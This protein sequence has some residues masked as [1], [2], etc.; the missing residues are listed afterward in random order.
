MTKNNA[1][2]WFNY[3]CLMRMHS[4]N[5]NL[6]LC[7]IIPSQIVIPSPVHLVSNITTFGISTYFH[8]MRTLVV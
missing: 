7:P 3:Y 4:V 5:L 8:R 1:P 2:G 6:Y